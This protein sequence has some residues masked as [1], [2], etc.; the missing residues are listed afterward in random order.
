[1][2]WL[3]SFRALAEISIEFQGADAAVPRVHLVCARTS[4]HNS[5]KSEREQRVWASNRPWRKLSWLANCLVILVHSQVRPI[6]TV[7]RSLK[8][9]RDTNF[10]RILFY[11][12]CFIIY[13]WI[14]MDRDLLARL[15]E[16]SSF[17]WRPSIHPAVLCNSC[18]WAASTDWN[19]PHQ[20]SNLPQ[21]GKRRHEKYL[22]HIPIEFFPLL[23]THY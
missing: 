17:S 4:H 5:K 8:S 18:T 2:K 15:P 19:H 10:S 11:L 6:H 14:V 1:M 12:C 16:N 7:C 23:V 22:E 9:T 3:T 21:E 20:D 13:V